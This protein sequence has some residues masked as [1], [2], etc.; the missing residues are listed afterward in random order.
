MASILK[1]L[2][3]APQSDDMIS[4][5]AGMPDPAFY[6]V[7]FFQQLWTKHSPNT[8]EFG[9]IPTEGYMPLRQSIA[10]LSHTKNITATPE[11]I[12]VVSGSQ[13]GLY[14][15]TKALLEPGDYVI[16]ETPTYIGAIQTFQAAGARLLKVPVTN[17]LDLELIEDYLIRYR[18]KLFYIL[19]TFQNPTGRTLSLA[20]RKALLELAARYRLVIVED[21]PYGSLHYD[22][23]PPPSLKALDEYGGV[24]YL[25]TFS[26]IIFPGLRTGWLVAPKEVIHRLSLE[27]QFIDLHSNNVSQILLHQFLEAG[28]LEKHLATVRS[29][30]SARR[31]AMA[32]ALTKYCSDTLRFSVPKGGFY[33]WCTLQF[34]HS[35]RMLLHEAAARGVTFVPGEAFYQNPAPTNRLRLCFVTHDSE[36]I[37]EG[38]RRLASVLKD[39]SKSDLNRS[40]DVPSIPII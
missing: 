40:T 28:I 39:G 26:K 27:K 37:V 25:G 4:L 7:D 22:Q 1:E 33:F 38:I 29:I 35:T 3:S 19:P 12:M 21:D 24:I 18:P 5:A 13:Q 10:S 9:H 32:K 34:D 8:A 6:P 17:Q 31:D 23:Q 36:Q 14:L 30:Y 2:V 11:D 20:E 16:T 15:L